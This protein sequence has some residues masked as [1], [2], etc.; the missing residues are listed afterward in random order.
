VPVRAS[1]TVELSWD[2][3]RTWSLPAGAANHPNP[4]RTP[5]DGA[6]GILVVRLQSRRSGSMDQAVVTSRVPTESNV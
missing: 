1:T 4:G 3:N 2:C 6:S 5:S